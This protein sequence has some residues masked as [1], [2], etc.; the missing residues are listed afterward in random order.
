MDTNH[1][2]DK[3]TNPFELIEELLKESE[4]SSGTD[5]NNKLSSIINGTYARKY[6]IITEDADGNIEY[7]INRVDTNDLLPKKYIS[8]K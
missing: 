1:A 2:I 7:Y 4:I 6:T 8:K 5:F 3:L